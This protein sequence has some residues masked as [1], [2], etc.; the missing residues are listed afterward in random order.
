MMPVVRGPAATRALLREHGVEPTKRFGQN[1]VT[2]PNT[3]RRIVELAGVEPGDHVLEIG[4]GTGALTGE[5]VAAG[6]EVTAVEVDHGLA[7]VVSSL[8]PSVRVVESDALLVDWD[9]LLASSDR[10]RLVANLPYNVGASIVLDVLQRASRVQSLLVMVQREVGERL[11]TPPGGRGSGIPSVVVAVHA[12][13][14]VVGSVPASVFLPQPHVE[15]VLVE[16]RRHAAPVVGADPAA[17]IAL[18]RQAFGQRRK[19]LRRSLDGIVDDAIFARAGVA[20][21]AR[22][23]SLDLDA[24]DRLT[25]AVAAGSR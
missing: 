13:A 17:L 18:A 25:D 3:V 16:L 1:F 10:W 19:M 8:L 15:S 9:E 5:L 14:R 11:A 12:S 20:A 2:D 23:E 7:R 22:P 24:W 21:E 6:A 4:P